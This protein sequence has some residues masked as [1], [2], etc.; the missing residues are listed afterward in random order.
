MKLAKKKEL[1]ISTEKCEECG[2][3]FERHK[4]VYWKKYCCKEC[5]IKAYWRR[6]LEK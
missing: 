6:K 2:V 1:Y 5:R 3:E 4:S